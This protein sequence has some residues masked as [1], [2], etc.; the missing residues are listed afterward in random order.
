MSPSLTKGIVYVLLWYM[1]VWCGF[2][3]FCCPLVLI[4]IVDPKRFRH[5]MSIAFSMWEMYPVALMKIIFG[6]EIILSGDS[7]DPGDQT[8]VIMNHRTRL[9]WNFLWG[10]MFHACRPAAHRLKMVLKSPIRHAPG[11]GWVMQIAGFLYIERNWSSDQDAMNEQLDYFRDIEHPVQLLIFP[12]GTDL[13]ESNI[14]K[15]NKF[16]DSH[17][18]CHFSRVLHPKTTGF[19]FLTKRLSDS[20]QLDSIYDITVAYVGNLPQSELDA[21]RGKF[22]SE[23][24]FHIKKYNSK[25]LPVHDNDAMKCWL[26][27]VWAKKEARLDKFYRCG[28]F[29]GKEISSNGQPTSNALYMAFLFWT[30]LQIILVW[31]L[32]NSGLMR[33]LVLLSSSIMLILSFTSRGVQHLEVKWYRCINGKQ[34]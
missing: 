4:A 6:T 33:W 15:S 27:Q 28:S 10:C 31:G 8:L 29:D 13:S 25:S 9:D 22:P 12:E 20:N 3:F 23:A 11:P 30:A 21:L 2:F 26:N 18:L 14:E 34:K 16:A 24:H 7:I 32:L 19:T 17:G 1:S 5:L